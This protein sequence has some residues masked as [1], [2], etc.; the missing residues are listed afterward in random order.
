MRPS[1]C[2]RPYSLFAITWNR[3]CAALNELVN[4]LLKDLYLSLRLPGAQQLC[5]S[6]GIQVT[7]SQIHGHC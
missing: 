7:V 3:T 4:V 5:S 2:Y 6:C 1:V